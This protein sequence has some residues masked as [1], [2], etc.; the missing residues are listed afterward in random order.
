LL[1]LEVSQVEVGN[2]SINLLKDGTFMVDGGV[3]FGQLARTQW[4]QFVKPD[5]RNRIRLGLNAVLVRT[6]DLNVLIDTG[7]GNKRIVE[8]KAD[9][10]LNGNK[11]SKGLKSFGLTA[12]DID[13]VVLTNLRFEHSGGCTK[14][15]RTGAA[16]PMFPKARYMVQKASWDAANSPNERYY[17]SFYEDDFEPLAERDL[18]HFVDGS[19]EVVPGVTV[20]LMEG[21]SKGNQVVFIQYGSERIIY[22]GD[23]IPT[24]FHLPL[25]HIPA[26]AEFPND[27]LVQKR[28]LLEMAMGDGWIIVFG[29]GNDCNAAYVRDRGGVPQLVPVDM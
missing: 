28:E 15:D 4:E 5:R 29:H 14:L 8:L 6:P 26:S 17:Q 16:I 11:L 27:T 3:I 1:F 22:A 13:I 23:L 12:R 18:V 21:P 20:K 24:P 25:H 10:S 9:Y 19:D 2:T 7:A